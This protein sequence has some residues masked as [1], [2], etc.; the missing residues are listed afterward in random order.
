MSARVLKYLQEKW[1]DR[2]RQ[3]GLPV[4]IRQLFLF[5]VRPVYR[6]HEDS[7]LVA[8]SI[9]PIGF[10][11]CSEVVELTIDLLREKKGLWS[12]AQETEKL[13]DLHLGSGCRGVM[14]EENG[15]LAGYAFVQFD[16]IYR[17]GKCGRF[18]VPS[19]GAVLKNLYVFPEFRGRGL[20]KQLNAARLAAIPR[21]CIPIVFVLPENRYAVRNL[22]MFGFAEM[23]RIL[24]ITWLGRITKQ[25]IV[26]IVDNKMSRR[27]SEYIQDSPLSKSAG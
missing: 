3:F 14:I 10:K 23:L 20:G 11:T 26:R 9:H 7:V 6:M 22:K 8:P 1:L 5:L 21:G 24:R 19:N 2:V 4:S 17:F 16:G 27:L 25:R 15:R 13:L 18:M 12:L